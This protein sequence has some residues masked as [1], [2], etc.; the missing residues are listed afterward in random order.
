M[1]NEIL[2]DRTTLTRNLGILQRQGVIK[3][4]ESGNDVQL[5]CL[6]IN[7]KGKKVL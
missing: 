1:A 3:I 5:T 6:H 4:T 2:I 7:D